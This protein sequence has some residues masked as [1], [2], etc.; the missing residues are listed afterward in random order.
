MTLNSHPDKTLLVHVSE[1]RE[2]AHRIWQQ[3]S[4]TLHEQSSK[5]HQWLDW[6]VT[7]H[8]VGKGCAAFQAYI[9]NVKGF[10]QRQRLK[11]HTPMSFVVSLTRGKKC[12]WEWRQTL[13]VAA[14]AAGHHS[15]FKTH[16]ELERLLRSTEGQ[17]F[18]VGQ[19]EGF[20]WDAL[21][22]AV[23]DTSVD[24]DAMID[25]GFATDDDLT[26]IA[27]WLEETLVEESLHELELSDAVAFRL[28]S[29]LV[30][31]ILLEADKAFLIISPDEREKFRHAARRKI[32][33]S[34]VLDFIAENK[35][36]TVSRLDPL[37]A[38][39]RKRLHDG[40]EKRKSHRVQT[41]TLPTG[42]GK[43]LL[44]TT[45]AL[46][47]REQ[48]QTETH[49]PP[50]IIVLPFLSII[51]QTQDI[52]AKLLGDQGGLLSYHSLSI[53]DHQDSEDPDT[54]EF[55]LD[56]WH[57]DVVITTFDQFLFALLEPRTRHQM[58]FH[59]LCDALIVMDEVQALPCVLW[60]IVANSL[61]QLTSL[62]DCRLLAMSATQ[63]GFLTDAVELIDNPQDVFS[64]L[65]RYQILL[66][67]EKPM[68]IDDFVDELVMRANNWRDGRVLVVLNTRK[69]AR[70]L[71][72]ALA[73]DGF[74]VEF[75][76]ADVTPRDRLAT[77]KCIELGKPC[78]VV[79]TQCIEAGVDIDMS[80]VIRD[81]APLDSL[82]QVA[83]RCNRNFN[84]PR[85]TIEVVS[86]HN[87][88]GKPYAPMIYDGVLLQE[89]RGILEDHVAT[90]KD[91][92][93][94]E[95]QI[96]GL[97]ESYFQELHQKK[98]LGESHTKS[99]A[100]WEEFPSVRELLRGRHSNQIAFIVIEQDL[101]L[102]FKLEEVTHIDDRWDRRRALR[103]LS[104][105]V[106]AVS[107]SIYVPNEFAPER[108]AE[109]DATGNFWLLRRGFYQA[110][111]G[112][113]LSDNNQIDDE[114]ETWG[115]I[116]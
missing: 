84:R 111:R 46:E 104:S 98:N 82:I 73:R 39:V 18:L 64:A 85:E 38:E 9:K 90:H 116:I 26:E 44:A 5:L 77:I 36:T 63:T 61:T 42:S 68:S 112:M 24:G 67:H 100:R 71:R 74:E 48:L 114:N 4:S 37:R 3:H 43:T 56:T 28:Q 109:R 95:E 89:T 97:T 91:R 103:K 96:Y 16:D 47:Q 58:R 113:D 1:V 29:Q 52:Y 51:E 70:K 40:M 72:D 23:L 49:T 14:C 2:A 33:P 35:R 102:E 22:Q 92:L 110:N 59:Q 60:D 94:L 50:V 76:S 55:F 80:L 88:N 93:I 8:D 108:F 86:L 65:A 10:K 79:S 45:W 7:M 106:A 21:S 57:G 34:V 15:E 81:F 31:S 75:L 41:M 20:D 107:V 53:R 83:G 17:D 54:A 19:L 87:E 25:A 12:Q 13:A 105:R 11:A 62:G 99:F 6:A 66:R 69:S 30:H 78:I 32:Y 101:E 115:A 27:E